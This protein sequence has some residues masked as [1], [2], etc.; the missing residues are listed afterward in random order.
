MIWKWKKKNHADG[1]IHTCYLDRNHH[2][3]RGLLS[4]LSPALRPPV[5]FFC[6]RARPLFSL[7]PHYCLFF[8]FWLNFAISPYTI[9]KLWIYFCTL[10]WSI[11]VPLLF[12][13]KISVLTQTIMVKFVYF[14]SIVALILCITYRF[15]IYSSF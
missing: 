1:C 6:S 4:F 14:D 2:S 9:I 3:Q 11:L 8:L 7:H 10:I 15:N 5:S 12:Y 13:F